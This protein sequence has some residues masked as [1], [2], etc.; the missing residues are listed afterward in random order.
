MG[1]ALG[2]TASSKA[3]GAV[4]VMSKGVT[5]DGFGIADIAEVAVEDVSASMAQMST[6]S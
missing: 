1:D 4:G 2:K 5:G 3:I 6:G